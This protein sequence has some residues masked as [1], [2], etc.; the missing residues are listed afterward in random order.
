MQT[1][2]K[3]DIGI[4]RSFNRLYTNVLGLLD[5]HIL[6]SDF[7][8]SEV[9]VLHEID[10]TESCTMKKLSAILCIDTGYL[11][12]ILKQFKNYGF[13]DTRQSPEDG[14]SKL[15]YLTECGR[16][17]IAELNDRSDEQISSL[18][19]PLSMSNQAKLVQNMTN[20]E[21][22]LTNGKNIR[23]ED[24][25]IRNNLKPGDIGYIIYMHGWIYGNEYNYSSVFESYVAMSFYEYLQD[26]NSN[27][28]RLW[29]AEHN[30]EIIGC[31]GVVGHDDRAQLR[32]FLLHPNYRG[33][34]LGKRLLNEAMTFCREN[35]FRR[36]YLLTSND[37]ELAISMYQKVGFVKVAA[38][39][40]NSWRSDLT[41]LVFEIEL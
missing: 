13:V 26:Y 3:K 41:E 2:I 19:E 7:S 29:I 18:I 37:L 28:S 33:I 21:T 11:S 4:I 5:Q 31:I 30:H 27:P 25:T 32:W 6:K 39:E 35:S 14:R 15:L 12:R 23:I 22:I 10:K 24:I 8:L 36:A 20:I 16:E 9:R 17:K 1:K 40:N 38:K 34:G